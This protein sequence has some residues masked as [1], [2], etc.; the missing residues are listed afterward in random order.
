[1]SGW[2]LTEKQTMNSDLLR[3]EQVHLTV[4]NPEVM[5]GNFSRWNQDTEWL[6]LL[7]T[8]PP[9]MFSAKKWQ[10][11]L[12]KDLEKSVSNEIFFAIRTLEGDPL[13][14]FIGLFDLFMQH[15]DT[16]VAIALGEREYWGKGYG[17]DA[18]R[19]IL[20]YAFNELNLRR[21]GLIVFEYN[22]RAI[23]S[24]EKAG[25]QLEGTVRKVILRDGK[26]WDFRYMGILREEWLALNSLTR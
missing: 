25:F 26:R 1:M 3:G 8:D 6:R 16:L 18:M 9:R 21:V 17:T 14:G 20:R 15:G 2:L 4:E 24:Y 12:E 10:A 11:W 22:P 5:A 13:I 7:D 19:I 23:R